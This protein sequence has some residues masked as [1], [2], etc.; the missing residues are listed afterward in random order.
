MFQD[1]LD[2]LS[3]QHLLRKIRPIASATGPTVSLDGR[4]VL[5]MAS[6]NYLGL[7]THPD[8]IGAAMAATERYGAGAGAARLVCGTLP[9]HT[10]L[11]SA[12]SQ[13]KGTEAAL[14]FSSGYAANI[15]IIPALIGKDGL[16]LADRLCHASLI[17]GCRLSGATFRVYRHCDMEHLQRLLARRSARQPTLIVTDGLFSMDG[18]LAPLSD[19]VAL[20]ERYDARLFVDD[21]HGTGVMGRTGKGSAEHCGVEGRLAF[22]MGTLSKALGAE[23]GYVVGSR[24]FISYLVNSCRSFIYTTA[25]APGSAA[26]A[27]EALRI[28]REDPARRERLWA[29]R[30]RLVRGLQDLGF[31]LTPTVSPIVPI[32]IGDADRALRMSHALLADGIYAPAIRPP[33]VP[34]ET[35]RIRMT[36]TAD[37]TPAHINQ[38]LAVMARAAKALSVL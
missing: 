2:R 11:E 8:V 34:P 10:E 1:Y 26:A 9:P 37:H 33:T 18:D 31:P 21:A 22:Q 24:A 32:L 14:A 23:G 25:P 13:F 6:N 17:D 28:V 29:N 36:V 4:E 27:T 19:L 35:S 15:G 20:A 12:L 3:A 38:A 7:A 5:L 30:D 16:I